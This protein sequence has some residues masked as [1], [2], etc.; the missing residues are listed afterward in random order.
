MR[1]EKTKTHT[2]HRLLPIGD[3]A[4]Y[5]A[6]KLNHS[7]V[8]IC[9]PLRRFIQKRQQRILDIQIEG[10]NQVTAAV[11]SGH[12]VL[13]TP[14]H[15]TYSDPYLLAEAA[16]QAKCPF[17]YM[18]A[19]Q[20]FARSD[21]ISRQVMRRHGCFSVDREGRD[22]RSVRQAISILE[23]AP[24]PLVI[25][26]EGEMYHV[27]ERVMPFHRGPAAIALAA[28]KKTDRKVVCIPCGLRY[29]FLN[30]PTSELEKLLDR[31][32]EVFFWSPRRDLPMEKRLFL[33]AE[34]ALALKELEYLGRTR[35]GP[36]SERIGQLCEAVLAKL[37]LRYGIEPAINISIR[38][39]TLRQHCLQQMS[40]HSGNDAKMRQYRRDLDNLFLVV[41][42]FSYPANYVAENP[43]LE[44][45]AETLD[46]L[47]EDL[48]GAPL[49]AIRADRGAIVK[50][51]EPIAI[52]RSCSGSTELTQVLEFRVQELLGSIDAPSIW[53]NE[54]TLGKYEVNDVQS[55][56][57]ATRVQE[58]IYPETIEA[59][60]NAVK[61]SIAD[62]RCICV[63]GGRHAM[64][65]QQFA[66]GAS[67]IDIKNLKQVIDFDQDSGRVTVG[68]GVMWLE[69]I[70]ALEDRQLGQFYPWSIRQKQTGV[71]NVS[72]G[73]SISANAHGRGLSFPPFASEV[74]SLKLVDCGGQLVTC[75]RRE[76]QELFSLVLGGYGLFGIIAEAT[77][78]LV[79]RQRVQRFVKVIPV[80]ELI[81]AVEERRK[82]GYT[83]GDCQYSIDLSGAA[84]EH[85]GVF[86]C[87][88]PLEDSQGADDEAQHLSLSD[89]QW[90]KLYTLARTDKKKAFQVYSQYYL[91]TDGQSYWS[92]THQ[93][94]AGMDY[95]TDV[96]EMQRG[97][98]AN[99]TEMI[100][101][102]YVHK[103]R[104]WEFFQDMRRE[105][106][107]NG[108]DLTY[109]TI[110]F[111]EKDED[112]FLAAA[113]EQTVCVL[114]N[115][116][117]IHTQSG[118]EQAAATFRRL[119]DA[120]LKYGGRYFLTYH[121][122]AT[123][124]Q[125]LRAYPQLIDFLK[126]KLK[127]DPNELFQSNWYRHF[128]EM[129]ADEL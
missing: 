81:P 90:S 62:G 71:D 113:T 95:Y 50:F 74:E 43:S 124:D 72:I 45:I 65:G 116:N 115:L 88:K 54:A 99:N 55:R 82:Q 37:E 31:L 127:Y 64:G 122:W 3:R 97:I 26:P 103:D 75:S 110:R 128:K 17:Y 70:K 48:L 25:F 102:F 59:L 98:A 10:L 109:G 129:F 30:D 87:Y 53:P 101:E 105:F 61:Q 106:L 40:E 57:N 89:E 94:S 78:R 86:S 60:R 4:R 33:V 52:D 2:M 20:V 125:A 80:R 35:Q 76:N 121:R 5:W 14:N 91:S 22:L 66:A 11:E 117:V 12:S 93:L 92:D 23:S 44:R 96:L 42:L 119:I 123:K 1:R 29:F 63:S 108:A 39:N 9:G 83:Y 56:L 24:E 77:L 28:A 34:G 126:S 73:G 120:A 112:C 19:W 104:F 58:I 114:C 68:A 107:E 38:V 27:G 8:Q 47:E 13:I 67:L 100:S 51:G 84:D 49:A 69:L 6:P 79:K 85:P 32:E 111:L 46:R 15:N 36:V 7:F 118:R 18:S 21:W 41:Q 16:A